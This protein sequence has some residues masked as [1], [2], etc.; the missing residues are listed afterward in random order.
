M[1]LLSTGY[2]QQYERTVAGANWEANRPLNKSPRALAQ[3]GQVAEW[4]INPCT[5]PQSKAVSKWRYLIPN[6][7]TL[8]LK[9][10]S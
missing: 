2:V 7:V 6:A 5:D 8:R 10:D 1:G 3:E 9:I 4:I